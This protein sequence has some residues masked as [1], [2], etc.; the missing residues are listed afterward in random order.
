MLRFGFNG[1]PFQLVFQPQT[2]IP[3]IS[4][5]TMHRQSSSQPLHIINQTLPSRGFSLFSQQQQQ[6]SGNTSVWSSN[7]PNSSLITIHNQPQFSCPPN[8]QQKPPATLRSRPMSAGGFTNTATFNNSNATKRVFKDSVKVN[9]WVKGM[10]NSYIQQQVVD[11]ETYRQEDD[12]SA[13]NGATNIEQEL[14]TK[15]IEIKELKEKISFLQN[16]VNTSNEIEQVKRD[17]SIAVSLVNTMQKDLTNKDL[18]ISKLAREIEGYK[19]ELKERD[20]AYKQLED[21]HN[22]SVDAKTKEEERVAKETEINTLKIVTYLRSFKNE[23][24]FLNFQSNRK[25]KQPKQE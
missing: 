15:S 21:K 12:S 14:K 25:L 18:T 24:N 5:T 7:V 9:S 16:Q 4:L 8:N 19:R 20:N 6:Q 1:T 17:K 11:S 23:Y 3:P 22:L 10:P 13:P 2:S